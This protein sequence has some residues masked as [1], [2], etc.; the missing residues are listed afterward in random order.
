[1]LTLDRDIALG[2]VT[3][4]ISMYYEISE[5]L[6]TNICGTIHKK[7]GGWGMFANHGRESL[8]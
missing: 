6:A 8:D 3:P 7:S 4:I 2:Y 5:H 1:M